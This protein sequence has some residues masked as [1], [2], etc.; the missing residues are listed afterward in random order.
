MISDS[1]SFSSFLLQSVTVLCCL[2]C[3]LLCHACL[4][5]HY[6]LTSAERSD[7]SAHPSFELLFDK[8][9]QSQSSWIICQ[10]YLHSGR[11]ENVQNI[12]LD[13]FL[14]WGQLIHISC[15][16]ICLEKFPV[17]NFKL[18]TK[19]FLCLT[20]V[21]HLGIM[22]EKRNALVWEDQYLFTRTYA[23]PK[24]PFP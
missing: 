23:R 13:L 2:F 16:Q 8:S 24:W 19:I 11:N 9:N 22:H 4:N 15:C 3:S 1:H 12:Y 5:L 6:I 20:I 14:N 7:F 10:W 21:N 18:G 17:C